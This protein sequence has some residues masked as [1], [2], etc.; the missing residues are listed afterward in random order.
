VA[1]KVFV[2]SKCNPS[3]PVYSVI[4]CD[5]HIADAC[6]VGLRA[7]LFFVNEGKSALT[8]ECVNFESPGK[9]WQKI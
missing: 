9:N 1:F 7:L 8:R 5:D 3:H 4:K 2:Y 6:C